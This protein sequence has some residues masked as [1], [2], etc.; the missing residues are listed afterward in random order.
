MITAQLMPLGMGSAEL[1]Q[2]PVVMCSFSE[3]LCHLA[4]VRVSLAYVFWHGPVGQF[5]MMLFV[6]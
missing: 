1:M 2:V 6:L 5:N 3:S 4:L